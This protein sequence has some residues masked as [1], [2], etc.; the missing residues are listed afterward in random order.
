MPVSKGKPPGNRLLASLP[1][2][3]RHQLLAH[4]DLV[5]LDF[6]QVLGESG[7]KIRHVY[8]PVDSFASLITALDDGHQ[9]EVGMI[10]D[11]GMVGLS[12]ALGVNTSPQHVLVQG[13]G[14]AL[15]MSATVFLHY[16]NQNVALRQLLHRYVYVLMSQLAQ[17][18]ACTHYHLLE[19][20]L[21]RWLL[22]TRDR[23]HSDSFRLTHQ[24]LAYMLG[25]RRVGV[26]EAASALHARGLISYSRGKITIQNGTELQKASCGCYADGNAI[27]ER[28]LRLPHQ[29]SH[30]L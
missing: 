26:S 2:R 28:T 24:F 18:A 29:T 3:S 10:G 1:D 5:Q 21:A 30:P 7:V 16:Y 14:T 4:C 6:A 13:A 9:L 11:E 8:F 23:A 27:Y 20:R 22:I 12:L 19:A 25:V 17:T 15:R